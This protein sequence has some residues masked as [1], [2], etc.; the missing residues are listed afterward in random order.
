MD[1]ATSTYAALGRLIAVVEATG[2][3]TPAALGNCLTAPRTYLLGQQLN[4]AIPK[5]RRLPALDAI[6]SEI[7]ETLTL[8]ALD[9]LP[10][11]TPLIDQGTMQIAYYQQR[12]SLPGAVKIHG[13]HAGVDW[14]AVDWSKSDSQ[15]AREYGVTPPAAFAA[16]RRHNPNS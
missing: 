2:L 3:L 14:S 7:M 6:V 1:A 12:S 5:L 8:E 9:A 11:A 13:A 4:R 10:Q 16:R 15:L